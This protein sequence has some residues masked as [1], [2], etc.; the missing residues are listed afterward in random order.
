MMHRLLA[1]MAVFFIDHKPA[2][3]VI[4]ALVGTN[5]LGQLV[6]EG[7]TKANFGWGVVAG[8]SIALIAMVTDRI[9]QAWSRGKKDQMGIA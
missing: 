5:G 4:A 7:V 8:G 1:E 9:L 2:L 6:Y 3:L